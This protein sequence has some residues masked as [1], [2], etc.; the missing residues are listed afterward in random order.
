M[1]RTSQGP[2]H[3]LICWVLTVSFPE[4]A[5]NECVKLTTYPPSRTSVKTSSSILPLFFH[6]VV[7]GSKKNFFLLP[8]YS[9]NNDIKFSK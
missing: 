2:T 5:G 1:S 4:C 9:G 8:S 6:S 3:S 7:F